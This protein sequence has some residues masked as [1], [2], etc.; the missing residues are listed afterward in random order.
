MGSRGAVS[1]KSRRAHT[2]RG[3]WM[4]HSSPTL[5]F[6]ATVIVES[7]SAYLS[8][9]LPLGGCLRRAQNTAHIKATMAFKVLFL[10]GKGENGPTFQ[11]RLGPLEAALKARNPSVHCEYATAPHEL[12]PGKYAWW[13]LPPNERSFTTAEYIGMEQTLEHV[14]SLWSESGPFDAVIAHSQGSILT[15]VLLAKA[16]QSD[17]AFRPPKAVLFG[18]AW[19]KPYEALLQ[20]LASFDYAG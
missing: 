17:Y 14:Q 20:S 13:Q 11:Q 18:A 7:C 3:K 10:H 1:N 9:S 4:R 2:K 6:I 8:S 16:L 12:G 15:S 5:I 19:P